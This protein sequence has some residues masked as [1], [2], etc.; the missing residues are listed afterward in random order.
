LTAVRE[1]GRRRRTDKVPL[2]PLIQAVAATASANVSDCVILN[3]LRREKLVKQRRIAHNYSP[4]LCA[5]M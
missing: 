5:H 2:T 3:L 4:P 1:F